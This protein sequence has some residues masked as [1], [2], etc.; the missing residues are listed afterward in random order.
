MAHEENTGK[1]PAELADRAWELANSIRT[2]ILVTK[3]G[4]SQKARPMS[5][6]VKSD[7]DA[8][9]FLTSVDADTVK[10]IAEVSTTTVVFADTSGNKYVTFNG[11]AVVENDR[12]K[13]KELW[14][15]FAKAWWESADDPVIR[16]IRFTPSAAEL[17]DSPGKLVA[18]AIMLTAAITGTKPAVGDH[19]KIKV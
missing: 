1:T 12:A 19:A 13:I 15:P 18:T 5:A 16:V 3:N 11:N 8:I 14:T 6:T 9:Y 2:A 17:W 7:E 4:A 10:Q